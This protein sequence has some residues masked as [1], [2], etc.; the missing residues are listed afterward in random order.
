MREEVKEVPLFDMLYSDNDS[1]RNHI[2]GRFTPT[3][4]PSLPPG[5]KRTVR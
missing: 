2:N 1:S 5:R 4:T 3:P